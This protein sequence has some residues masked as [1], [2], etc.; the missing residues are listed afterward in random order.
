MELGRDAEALGSFDRALQLGPATAQTHLARGRILLRNK[1]PAEALASLDLALAFSHDDVEVFYQRGL[2]LQALGRYEEA[3]ACLDRASAIKGDSAEVVNARGAVLERLDRSEEALDCFGR[4]VTLKPDHVGAYTNAGNTRTALGRYDKA[5]RD[6]DAAL[7]IAPDDTNTTWS[8]SLLVLSLGDFSLGWPLYESRLRLE[9]EPRTFDVPRWTGQESLAGKTILVHAEQ[10]LG[11]TVHF[12]R[13]VRL[14]E[15]RGAHV[16]LEVQPVLVG[17]LRSLRMRGRLM[18]QDDPIPPVD[19]H[20]PLLSLPLGFHTE[21]AT[22]PGDVPYL[23]ADPD[24]VSAW[25]AH[26]ESI[27]GFKVGI[28]WQGNVETER[29]DWARSRSFPLECMSPLAR[30]D[31]VRFVSL[32]KGAAADQRRDVSFSERIVELTDPKDLGEAAILETAALVSALD[33][34]VT[35]D[36]LLAHVCGALGVP[37]WTVVPAV[38]D[39]RWLRDRGDNPWYPTMRVFR[40]RVGGGWSEVFEEAAQMLSVVARSK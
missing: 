4:A 34:V 25:R 23:R 29:Q 27:P 15:D 3:L 19:F 22:I 20:C 31:G 30:V 37:V 9:R 17:L 13:Y 21:L 16:V 24:A 39:W 6:F 32:Q 38:P 1:R 36:T 12:C 14:L 7:A 26:V 40:R 11:D 33:L 35:S 8:K 10:G 2:A 18:A 28:N 5:L